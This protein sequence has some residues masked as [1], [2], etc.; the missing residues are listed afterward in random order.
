MIIDVASLRL[1]SPRLY[2]FATYP[3]SEVIHN[4]HTTYSTPIELIPIKSAFSLVYLHTE[5]RN[6]Q[7]I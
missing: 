3:Q 4:Q 6:V 7:T 2:S 5:A 1:T